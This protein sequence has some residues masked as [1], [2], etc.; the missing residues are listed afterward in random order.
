MAVRQRRL[1]TF[2]PRAIALGD[3]LTGWPRQHR[4][5]SRF[6]EAFTV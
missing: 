4:G 3:F 2:Q 1:G 6:T 5:A